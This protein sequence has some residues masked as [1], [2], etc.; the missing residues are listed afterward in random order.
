[1]STKTLVILNPASA[2]GSTGR[3]RR[4]ILH[5]IESA[6]GWVDLE[7]TSGPRDAARLSRAAA[8]RGVSQILVAGGDGTTSEIVE[9]LLGAD[10]SQAMRPTLGLLP[11][12]SGGDLARTL[13]LP[14]DLDGALEVIARGE[15]RAIDAGRIELRRPDGSM[16]TH[17][18]A[19][20]ASAGLSGATVRLVGRLAKTVGPR[21]GFVAGA[22]AAIVSHRPTEMS[23]EIDGE[24][25]FVGPVSMVV[26]ANGCYFGAGMKVAPAARVDDGLFEVVLVRGLSMPR[27]LANLPAFYLGRH[28][29][30]PNVSFHAARTLELRRVP[31][32]AQ[33]HG[34][35]KPTGAPTLELDGESIGELPIRA[36]VMAGALEVF[37]PALASGV[38]GSPSAF[39]IAAGATR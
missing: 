2:A 25:V 39:P 12:G 7:V 26:A 33:G 30:H 17:F 14:R 23:V 22:V 5:R 10:A 24:P 4:E 36:E 28:G 20:E 13:A 37:A 35:S 38:S 18:F 32:A 9:G 21:I 8:E 6:L 19:N 1:M 29:R 31:S 3:R 15:R 11:L 16:Q 34:G 27:L